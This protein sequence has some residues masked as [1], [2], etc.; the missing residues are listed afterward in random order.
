MLL[1][2][3]KERNRID[4]KD[5][6]VSIQRL[7]YFFVYNLWSWNRVF[8][9]EERCIPSSIFWNGWPLGKGWRGFPPFL[10]FA[11]WLSVYVLYTLQLFCSVPSFLGQYI[12]F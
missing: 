8:L 2:G 10:F 12:A 9:S 1:E 3:W 7:N 6:M 4:F 11:V 5:G